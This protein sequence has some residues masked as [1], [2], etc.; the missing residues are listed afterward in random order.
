MFGLIIAQIE[1]NMN[2]LAFEQYN[3]RRNFAVILALLLSFAVVSE[4]SAQSD[5]F[6]EID[7]LYAEQVTAEAGTDVAVRFYMQNDEPISTLSVPLTFDNENVTLQSVD[8][9]GSRI[10]YIS[11]KLTVPGTISDTTDHFMISTFIIFEDAI[12]AGDG[13]LF[14]AHFSVSENAPVGTLYQFD[15]LF[16]PPGGEFI[17]VEASTSQPINP[18]Y[19]PAQIRIVEKNFPP[20]LVAASSESLFEGDTLSLLISA[21]DPNNDSLIFVCSNKPAGSTFKIIDKRSAEFNWVPD[22]IGPYSSDGAP[23]NLHIWVSDGSESVET[24]IPITVLNKNRKPSLDVISSIDAESGDLIQFDINGSDA[25]FDMIQYEI[26]G[27]PNGAQFVEGSPAVL[28]WQTTSADTGNF[29]ITFI[30]SDP[31]GYADTAETNIYLAAVLSYDLSIDSVEG[32]P[33]D[34]IEL[35]VMLDNK[36]PITSFNILINYDP[37]ALNLLDVTNS[38]SRTESFEYFTYTRDDNNVIGNVRVI[39]IADQSESGNFLDTG[40]GE[41]FTLD[42]RIYSNVYLSGQIIPVN[43]VFADEPIYDDNT[44]E[45][46]LGQKITQAEITYTNG[47]VSV[48]SLGEVIIGDINLNG[49]A[50][51]IGDAVYF[52][53]YFISPYTYPL[54]PLQ[55]ANSDVNRDNIVASVADLVTLINTIASGANYSPKVILRENLEAEVYTVKNNYGVSVS[56]NTN[57]EVGA[58]L[59]TVE[60]GTFDSD[61]I[62]NVTDGMTMIT[63]DTGDE[64]RIL[65]YSMD[66]TRL[67]FGSDD[68][69]T[70]AHSSEINILDAELASSEGEMAEIVSVSKGTELPDSFELYQNYPNPFNPE[71]TIGFALP[72]QSSVVLEVYNVLGKKVKVLINETMPAGHHTAVWDGRN[73]SGSEAASG[74]YLYRLKTEN[75]QTSKKMIFLK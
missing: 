7:R 54:N 51:D 30:V 46:S 75:Y 33:G 52:T 61:D 37:S 50:Y 48:L 68:I 64:T 72:Q 12:P 57:F 6:G 40:V 29:P 15:T 43:F 28:N 24:D 3:F 41:L 38:G 49:I 16:Y 45:D 27:L 13:L 10:E 1:S 21:N 34:Y 23:F 58:V 4:T 9:T 32:N 53:N 5:L 56:Y 44:F 67:P 35:P 8:F 2:C 55:L 25:D 74:I 66:G 65:I 20:S 71:T 42:L 59:L 70:F 19:E 36:L 47:T 31:Q 22:Y 14:T 73:Q 60:N 39:G 69:L 62:V 26:I 63:F 18:I 17:F 11:N